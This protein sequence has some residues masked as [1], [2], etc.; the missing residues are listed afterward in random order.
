MTYP[1]D[2]STVCSPDEAKKAREKDQRAQREIKAMYIQKPYQIELK[3]VMPLIPCMIIHGILETVFPASAKRAAA[4]LARLIA[5]MQKMNI[6]TVNILTPIAK[7]RMSLWLLFKV[8]T[9]FFIN[10][11]N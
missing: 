8:Q 11:F 9:Y 5:A 2:G 1:V 4:S 7:Y 6:K 10:S 3:I